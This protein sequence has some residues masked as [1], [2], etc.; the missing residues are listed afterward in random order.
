MTDDSRC[1]PDVYQRNRWR[2]KIA[3]DALELGNG[4]AQDN[5]YAISVMKNSREEIERLLL[6]TKAEWE[7]VY[8]PTFNVGMWDPK[9]TVPIE[10]MCDEVEELDIEAF[11]RMIEQNGNGKWLSQVTM[12]K[13]EFC[14]PFEDS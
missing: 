1:H 5:E 9:V 13:R 7:V 10:S 2:V 12:A 14:L 8:S 6:T 4:S 3:V 11:A